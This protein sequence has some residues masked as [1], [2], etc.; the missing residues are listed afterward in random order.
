MVL[1]YKDEI[2]LNN[3]IDKLPVVRLVRF[4]VRRLVTEYRAIIISPCLNRKSSVL[5]Y[6]SML[7][8]SDIRIANISTGMYM[9]C[10]IINIA[11]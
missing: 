2:Y 8:L 10:S 6:Y 1:M 3:C 7:K 11:V 4:L 9:C 5:C